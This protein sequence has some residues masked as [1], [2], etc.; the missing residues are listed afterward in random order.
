MEYTGKKVLELFSKYAINRNN[1]IF[2]L[3]E[4]HLPAKDISRLP[5]DAASNDKRETIS[6]LEFGAGEGEFINRFSGRKNFK[7]YAVEIDEEYRKKLEKNHTT[8]SKIEDAP[9]QLDF[10]FLIDVLEHLKD[11]LT[12][13]KIFHDKLKKGGK[14]FI[15]VPA[16]KE[17]YSEFD[18]A[19][20]HYRRYHKK[21]LISKV[22]SAGFKT[23]TCKY[24][25]S[26][27]YFASYIHNKLFNKKEPSR[28]SLIVYDKF[29]IPLSQTI[30]YLLPPFFGK[31]LWIYAIVDN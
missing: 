14:L 16:R 2:K 30:E 25:E 10:I 7:T 6:I 17:L 23:V 3:I 8:L 18:K 12:Y 9:K 29:I 13:L 19:I 21:E 15:Y 27:G 4:K 20:G 28:S 1:H 24:C 22:E 5:S 31:S 26:L 11:D